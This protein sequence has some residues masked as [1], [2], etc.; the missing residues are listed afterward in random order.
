MGFSI[1]K[2]CLM[3]LTVLPMFCR[4]FFLPIPFWTYRHGTP[5]PVTDPCLAV[6][7]DIPEC[8]N[9]IYTEGQCC[10][11]CYSSQPPPTDPCKYVECLMLCLEAILIEGQC[12]PVC[13]S[14]LSKP[15]SNDTCNPCT[16][17]ENGTMTCGRIQCPKLDCG[18]QVVSKEE[19]C[20]MCQ[21]F[22]EQKYYF[23]GRIVNGDPC[24]PC[25]CQKDGN[26][27][28][29]SIECPKLTCMY[30]IIPTGHCCPVCQCKQGNRYYLNGEIVAKEMCSQ[31]IC[32]A[33]GTVKEKHVKCPD[34]M[35]N[36]DGNCCPECVTD[37]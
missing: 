13:S 31:Q 36:K 14:E 6:K 33:D 22:H 19:C 4:G 32:Q 16:Y 3:L 20:P 2:K 7:C 27:K 37:D 11:V 26:I 15:G 23:P 30:Q 34:L 35:C 10:P 18:Y 9:P 29:E 21:C 12:C 5:K 17:Q 8:A 24:R 1:T 25:L 28:C